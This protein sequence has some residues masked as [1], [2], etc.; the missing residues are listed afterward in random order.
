MISER[1]KP[2]NSPFSSYVPPSLFLSFSRVLSILKGIA[3][4]KEEI[5]LDR[6]TVI[7]K[8]NILKINEKVKLKLKLKLYLLLLLLFPL[9]NIWLVIIQVETSPQYFFAFSFIGDFLFGDT[10][11]D[12]SYEEKKKS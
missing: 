8:Q 2:E 10:P 7:L 5:D 11:E 6:M 4:G 3:E 12:V 9:S 1:V